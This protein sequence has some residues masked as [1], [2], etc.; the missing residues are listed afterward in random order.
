MISRLIR[1]NVLFLFLLTSIDC[2]ANETVWEPFPE[3]SEIDDISRSDQ[4]E[5]VV[6]L[7]MEQDEEALIW[8][9][10]RVLHYTRQLRETWK[11]LTVV[12]LSHGNEMVALQTELNGLYEDLHSAV[13]QLVSEHDVLFQV[14]G[15]Y[16]FFSNLD[17]SAFLSYIDVVPSAPAEIENYR[18]MGYKIVNLELTW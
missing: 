4:L 12:V 14:C 17:A 6:F 8:V 5:G 18:L 1:I 15:S 10:P 11:D 7:V 13:K 16:A 3:Q 9:L 2:L